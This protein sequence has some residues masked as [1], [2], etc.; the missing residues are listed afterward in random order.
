MFVLS[1]S[2]TAAI[3]DI[4]PKSTVALLTVKQQLKD[5]LTCMNYFIGE[6]T[7]Y[8]FFPPNWL[9]RMNIINALD[10]VLKGLI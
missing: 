8:L 9:I 3:E 1:Y 10:V 6:L 2:T 4:Q 5:F 7:V